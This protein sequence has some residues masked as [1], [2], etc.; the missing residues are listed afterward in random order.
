[1]RRA[2]LAAQLGR[3]DDAI[4]VLQSY[5]DAPAWREDGQ[6]LHSVLIDLLAEHRLSDKLRMRADA[7]DWRAAQRLA[8]LLAEQQDASQLEA[9]VE[10]G[11]HDAAQR[12]IELLASQGAIE[13]AQAMRTHALKADGTIDDW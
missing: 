10:A 7:E 9:E 3:V 4:S 12:L 13:K 6:L 2:E 5:A 8:F 11:T 1:V